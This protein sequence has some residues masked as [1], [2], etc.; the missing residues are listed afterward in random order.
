MAQAVSCPSG[1]L[2]ALL[3]IRFDHAT[4]ADILQQQQEK[5]DDRQL[6]LP[7]NATTTIPFPPLPHAPSAAPLPLRLDAHILSPDG[8]SIVASD[9]VRFTVV[10]SRRCNGVGVVPDDASSSSGGGGGGVSSSSS[11]AHNAAVRWQE[12]ASTGLV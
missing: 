2:Q 3:L 5:E 4:A 8:S 1:V 10:D 7:C 11:A 6:L 9:H 12:G